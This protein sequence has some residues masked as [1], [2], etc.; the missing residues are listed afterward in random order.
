MNLQIL[1]LKNLKEL[2]SKGWKVEI[3][4]NYSNNYSANTFPNYRLIEF[5]KNNI[6]NRDD[7]D[8]TI[9][10]EF[11]HAQDYEFDNLNESGISDDDSYENFTESRAIFV[12]KNFPEI[13]DTIK[14]YYPILK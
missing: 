4:N 11:V 5:Y 3:L 10:H 12:Y 1:T 8:L 7:F 13:L 9:L 14:R 2:Y 6:K